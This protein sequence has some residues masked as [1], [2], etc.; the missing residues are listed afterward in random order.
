MS[1]TTTVVKNSGRTFTWVYLKPLLS[2][3]SMFMRLKKNCV[4]LQERNKQAVLPLNRHQP[5]RHVVYNYSR[6]EQRSNV[7]LA[8][9]FPFTPGF[10]LSFKLPTTFANKLFFSVLSCT[11]GSL[12]L[13]S[14]GNFDGDFNKLSA[15]TASRSVSIK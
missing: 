10:S 6:K 2:R 7:H 5:V 15:D 1:F 12:R 13:Y 9:F 8:F 4:I 11:D 3:S 14:F